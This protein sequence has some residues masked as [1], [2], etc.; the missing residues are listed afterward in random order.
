MPGRKTRQQS[1]K[2]IVKKLT[3]LDYHKTN[4]VSNNKANPILSWLI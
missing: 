1:L 4:K 3:N 2:L